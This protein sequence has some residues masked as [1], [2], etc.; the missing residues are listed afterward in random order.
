MLAYS[1]HFYWLEFMIL[2][3]TLHTKGN[4]NLAKEP[5]IYNGAQ[6]SRSASQ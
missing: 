1:I 6:H 2:E 3:G 4:T 5:P